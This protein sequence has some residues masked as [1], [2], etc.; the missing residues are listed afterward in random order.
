MEAARLQGGGE[1]KKKVVAAAKVA[2][3]GKDKEM[4]PGL[5]DE[6]MN[7]ADRIADEMANLDAPTKKL[8][9]ASKKDTEESSKD[10]AARF[11]ATH[12]MMNMGHLLGDE[13]SANAA[14][15]AQEEAAVEKS[16]MN[17]IASDTVGSIGAAHSS[18]PSM[19]ADS[20]I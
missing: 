5:D 16:K 13:M 20:S 18:M 4:F 1:P 8:T 9:L 11:F 12:G 17:S 14:K 10:R 3:G 15:A 6:L 7:K 19:A 2:A